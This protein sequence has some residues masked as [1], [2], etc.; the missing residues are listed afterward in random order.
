MSRRIHE[1]PP[2]ELE[3]HCTCNKRV[4]EKYETTV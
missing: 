3:T 2:E 4:S 1:T